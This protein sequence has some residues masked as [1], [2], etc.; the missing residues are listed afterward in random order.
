MG[1]FSD[2][3]GG[4]HTVLRFDTRRDF[5]GRQTR[6]T[7]K[8]SATKPVSTYVVDEHG[9]NAYMEGGKRAVQSCSYGGTTGTEHGQTV[10]VSH[11]GEWCILV[12]NNG[13]EKATIW[14]EVYI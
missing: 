2:I 3:P 12:V 10:Y 13:T 8:L 5:W 14:Y 6:F 4:Q 1:A 9:V 11:D 7:F